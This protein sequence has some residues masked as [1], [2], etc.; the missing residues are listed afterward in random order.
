MRRLLLPILVVA[1]LFMGCATNPVTG[2]RELVLVSESHEMAMGKEHYGPSRQMQGGDYKV[3]PELTK[4][5]KSV[6]K[7]LSAVSDRKL[8]YEFSVLNNSVPNAWA[9]PGG[10][11]AV[12]RGLLVELK[13]EAEMAAVLG[14]EIVHAAARHGA[15]NVE[16]GMLLQG[17][18]I[19]TGI[20]A[21]DKDYANL[22]IAGAQVAAALI[23]HKYGR[24]AEREADLYGMEY[25]KRAG[26][27]PQAAVGL[28]QT[29]VRLSKNRRQDWLS[30]LFASHPPSQE[31]VENNRATAKRLGIG[32][33]IGTER[34]QGKL[35]HLQRTKEAYAAYDKGRKALGEGDIPTAL[36]MA[37]KA[38]RIEPREGHFHALKGDVR[39]S[40]KHLKKALV[41]YNRA[42]KLNPEFFHYYVQRGI[43]RE[44]LGNNSG[45]RSDLKTSLKFLPTAT[46]LNSLGNIALAEGNRQQAIKYYKGAAGSKSELG[47]Q[48]ARSLLRLDLPQNPNNYLQVRTGVTK[49]GYVMVKVGNPNSL[50]VRRVRVVIQYPDSQGRVRRFFQD[51]DGVIPPGKVA[52]IQTPLGPVKDTAVL[53]NISAGI[54]H[55]V[56]AE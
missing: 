43:T 12:N 8:P 10:K 2:K 51:V 25:M 52:N 45:A 36:K 23:S 7:R 32:G 14:H 9:L 18:I 34:Y 5:V 1:A 27:D 47:Q 3:D 15:K 53:K 24:D 13:N 48:A 42:I 38:I 21:R 31:R 35:A 49:K 20:A 4:Y 56:L 28:Q 46:A 55:A 16:R 30:G 50:P 33:E 17:A 29:F 54:E 40:Q 41:N 22:A 19:A 26:Y 39:Y 44:Q 11:I 37:D 6:G